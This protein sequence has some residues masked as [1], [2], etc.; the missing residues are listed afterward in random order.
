[1]RYFSGGV[2]PARAGPHDLPR[3]GRL[4][5]RAPRILPR[6][7]GVDVRGCGRVRRAPPAVP[8]AVACVV[9]GQREVAGARV[10]SRESDALRSERTALRAA[11]VESQ[12]A[13]ADL[14]HPDVAVPAVAVLQRT[15]CCAYLGPAGRLGCVDTHVQSIGPVKLWQFVVAQVFVFPKIFL[16]VFIG[17]R[18]A[19]L[20]DGDQRDK[21]D[22]GECSL[23]R[24]LAPCADRRC[25]HEAAQ[26]WP[27]SRQHVGRLRD[28]L[29]SAVHAALLFSH[30]TSART[31]SCI[32]KCAS[33]Y[34]TSRVSPQRWTSLL[35]RRS[36][37]R[38]RRCSVHDTC[39]TAC[40]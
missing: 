38:K 1:M 7:R 14:P 4:R 21:M 8:H 40:I 5:V 29:V 12:G 30:L 6:S 9:C 36:R 34:V 24:H 32:A 22:R 23:Q 10:C 26:H 25:S 31:G 16:S 18:A 20:A 2:L 11:V 27:H 13:A 33:G 19:A 39:S 15:V 35:Q 28:Q 3:P 17:S 37:T